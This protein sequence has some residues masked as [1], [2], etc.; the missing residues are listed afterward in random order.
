VPEVDISQIGTPQP[1]T[2]SLFLLVA[3]S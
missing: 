1:S 2:P 3:R